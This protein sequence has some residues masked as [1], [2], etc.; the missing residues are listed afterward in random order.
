MT[1][2]VNITGS[3]SVTGTGAFTSTLTV[4][5]VTASGTITMTGAA[6]GVN[7][8]GPT[9]N[10][11]YFA[12]D[13]SVNNS[14]TRWR[15]G[16]TGGIAG[17]TSW[18]V[19]NQ[20]NNITPLTLSSTGTA[21]FSGNVGIG[22]TS[23]PTKFAVKDGTDTVLQYYASSADG[24]LG[25]G[26]EAGSIGAGGK[27]FNLLTGT[28]FTFSTGGNERMR[29]TS[30]GNVG[31]GT[32]SPLSKLDI[33]VGNQTSLGLFSACGASITSAGGS[34]GN[35]YQ[36]SFGYGGGTYGSSTIAGLTESST[37]YNTGALI[38]ATRALTTDS[39]PI[40]RMRITSGG[41]VG[42]GTNS[43]SGYGTTLQIAANS[44]ND[45]SFVLGDGTGTT[46]NR[47][48]AAR[49]GSTANFYFGTDSGSIIF[50][51][52]LNPGTSIGTERM[53]ITSDGYLR[54]AGA[55]IQ[56]N[57]D[58]AAANSLDDYEEGTFTPV[59][60]GQTTAGA[61]TYSQQI[62][63]YTKVGRVVHI[64]FALAW[65][66]HTGTGTTIVT[67]FPFASA[68]GG[69]TPLAVFTYG[70]TMTAG[71]VPNGG[72]ISNGG[73]QWYHW[74]IPTGGGASSGIPIYN[75]TG[76]I[77]VSGTYIA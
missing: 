30:G 64:Y 44:S 74:Q 70:E 25:M 33:S 1:G 60:I 17:F 59:I 38:F 43:I 24:Y 19:Y 31:I 35:L 12:T 55:G 26:N 40:E 76:E 15:F 63:K 46:T 34:T 62:G 66:A 42:I 23:P 32:S 65:S 16:H 11:A 45:C 36:I 10:P 72:I 48:L 28:Q 54:L 4:G 20:T 41:N 5:N 2:S 68:A 22:T 56:F 7:L 51:T 75:G 21:S 50:A 18:D 37:G 57:G 69:Q 58:T 47:Y 27:S 77:Q 6:N 8:I 49:P 29:I 71:N 9:G 14:G 61:G 67:G 52:G 13:Q 39:A 3:L 73:T 53:R